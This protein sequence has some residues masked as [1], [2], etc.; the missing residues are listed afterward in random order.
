MDESGRV[1]Y[2]KLA[3]HG[4]TESRIVHA[5]HKDLV[6]MDIKDND[7]AWLRPSEEEVRAV[8]Q[9]TKEAL[10]KIVDGQQFSSYFFLFAF[11]FVILL[12]TFYC[13]SRTIMTLASHFIA[14]I[15][16]LFRHSF[17][18]PIVFHHQ[19]GFDLL[20]VHD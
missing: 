17:I 14:C 19:L 20:L 10:E 16:L 5:R 8:A 3:E 7:N 9:R 4:H 12:Y 2:E 1:Q 18:L 13:L 15:T 6:P 11:Y